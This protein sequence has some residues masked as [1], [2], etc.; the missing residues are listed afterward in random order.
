MLVPSSTPRAYWPPVVSMSST[1]LAVTV[2]DALLLSMTP[3]AQACP[4]A[5][6]AVWM[7]KVAPDPISSLLTVPAGEWPRFTP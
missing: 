1:P 4:P 2:T 7:R 6:G 3:L 5:T